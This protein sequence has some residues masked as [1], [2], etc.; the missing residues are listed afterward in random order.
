MID[1][2]LFSR[3][4]EAKHIKLTK[5]QIQKIKTGLNN[6]DF[7]VDMLNEVTNM[8]ND[9]FYFKKR[10]VLDQTNHLNFKFEIDSKNPSKEKKKLLNQ[11][12]QFI[13]DLIK[14]CYLIKLMKPYIVK[15]KK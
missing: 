10:F 11:Q 3:L 4:I 15:L 9:N 1:Q 7:N 14:F 8:Y 2:T 6:N 12:T 13:A 5:A